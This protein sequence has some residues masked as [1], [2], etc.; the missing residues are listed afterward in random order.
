MLLRTLTETKER[1]ALRQENAEAVIKET[2]QE[3]TDNEGEQDKVEEEE[4]CHF[5][6]KLNQS[7]QKRLQSLE[8]LH[9]NKATWKIV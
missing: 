9:L 3:I 1:T 4:D 2:T 8:S 5:K 7:E 6:R